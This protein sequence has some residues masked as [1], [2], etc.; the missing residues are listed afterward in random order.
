M[1]YRFSLF[2]ALML[3]LT[4]AVSAQNTVTSSDGSFWVTLPEGFGPAG[5]PP[6]SAVLA[7][8]R[9][10]SGVSLFCEKGEAVN[11]DPKLYADKQKQMLFD[12]GAQ[13][14]GSRSSTLAEQPACSFLVGGVAQGKESLFVFNQRD[15]ALYAFVLNYPQGQR[16]EAA[17]LWNQI[18]PTFKFAQKE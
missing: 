14:H 10:G 15:D 5:N 16:Q 18:A 13:I 6:A 3:T 1:I 9:P 7:V 8:E 2:L 11:L 17:K 4:V 12:N